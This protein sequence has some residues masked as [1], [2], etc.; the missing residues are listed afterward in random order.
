MKKLLAIL[1]SVMMA[2]SLAVP[3][4]ADGPDGAAPVAL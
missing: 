2:A 4:F 3:A 1:L